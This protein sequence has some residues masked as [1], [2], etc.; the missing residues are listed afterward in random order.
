MDSGAQGAPKVEQ[1]IGLQVRSPSGV[2]SGAQGAPIIEQ[3]TE[4]IGFQVGSL[5]A[6]ILAS[7]GLL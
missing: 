6:W 1:L 2:N 4:L 5:L 7:R 3:L